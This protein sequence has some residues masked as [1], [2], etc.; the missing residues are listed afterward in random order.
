MTRPSALRNTGEVIGARRG[1]FGH[2]APFPA[3]P[4]TVVISAR[5]T[6]L[7]QVARIAIASSCEQP[8]EQTCSGSK[9]LLQVSNPLTCLYGRLADHDYT[10]DA[11]GYRYNGGSVTSRSR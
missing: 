6:L 11:R 2:A 9:T 3:Q 7:A 1:G 5:A 4:A 10:C 8:R